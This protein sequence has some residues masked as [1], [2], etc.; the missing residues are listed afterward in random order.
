MHSKKPDCK[1]SWALVQTSLGENSGAI[2]TLAELLHTPYSTGAG[3]TPI[4]PAL[5][6][7][8]PIWDPLRSEPLSKN[9]ARKN[10]NKHVQFLAQ[11]NLLVCSNYDSRRIDT[12]RFMNSFHSSLLAGYLW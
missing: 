7:L 12:N 10:S 9:S 11:S 3:R 5:L 6:R 2:S 1:S 8:D 4:T